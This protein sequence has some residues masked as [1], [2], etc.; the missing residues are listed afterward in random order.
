MAVTTP[1][2]RAEENLAATCEWLRRKELTAKTLP[3]DLLD[4]GGGQTVAN[5]AEIVLGLPMDRAR[6]WKKDELDG[7][8]QR[9]RDARADSAKP[10][11]STDPAPQ[12]N[13]L[14]NRKERRLLLDFRRL[15]VNAIAFYR[16]F[17]LEPVGRW[18]IYIF[19]DR[20]LTYAAGIRAVA[21]L[22]PA[23]SRELF[24]HLVLFE[25][26]HHEFYH[27]LVECAATVL[28]ILADAGGA[29]FPGYLTY[30]RA[31]RDKTFSWH[32]HQPL[33]EALANAYAYNSL[34]FISRVK[35]GYRDAL[36]WHY[37][38]A[39]LP[40]WQSEGPG[41][42]EAAGYVEGNQVAGNA[43]LLAMLLGQPEHPVLAQV[44]ASVMP[45][46]F[47]AFVG[48]PDIPTHLVGSPEAVAEFYNMVP[49][50]NDTYCNLF[51]PLDDASASA[52]LKQQHDANEAARRAQKLQAKRGAFSRGPVGN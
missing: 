21:P 37:Q 42:R 32:P 41:Y 7:L 19:V 10:K 3:I 28:E 33:E 12:L 9:W 16:P 11:L 2:S 49:A 4:V 31:V 5:A 44:A 15:P 47:S 52:A 51:W 48:K 29:S 45:S 50:P 20:L 18:G 22:F 38:Q 40:Q 1:L 26:F 30:R 17:H 13:A 6:K 39:L 14:L 35:T 46:G 34:G 23:V 25:M 27:H 43:Q 8:T 24:L 36:V